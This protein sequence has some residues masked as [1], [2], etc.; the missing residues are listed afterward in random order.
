MATPRAKAQEPKCL[1]PFAEWEK[2][3]KGDEGPLRTTMQTL[4]ATHVVGNRGG[5]SCH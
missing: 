5:R 4:A 3:P 1:L 2:V